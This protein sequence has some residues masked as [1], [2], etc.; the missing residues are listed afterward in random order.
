LLK[1]IGK[2]IACLCNEKELLV[3]NSLLLREKDVDITSYVRSNDVQDIL[4]AHSATLLGCIHLADVLRPGAREAIREL[5][6]MNLRTLLLTGD[7]KE[8]AQ[9]IGDQL[10]LDDVKAEKLPEEKLQEVWIYI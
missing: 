10:S 5:K 4:V 7:T 8:I 2:G 3:G 6:R 1:S 9:A